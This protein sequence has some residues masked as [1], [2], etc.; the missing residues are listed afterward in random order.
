MPR[1]GLPELEPK[2]DTRGP[3]EGLGGTTKR[4]REN[5]FRYIL[6]KILSYELLMKNR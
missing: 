4:L 5:M 6:A 2:D 1:V 3:K